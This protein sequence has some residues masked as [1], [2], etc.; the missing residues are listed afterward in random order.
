MRVS[1]NFVKF[2]NVFFLQRFVSSEVESCLKLNDTSLKQ[3]GSSRQVKK[4]IAEGIY[5]EA[6]AQK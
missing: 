4:N 2:L 1:V 6:V 3:Q 5:F